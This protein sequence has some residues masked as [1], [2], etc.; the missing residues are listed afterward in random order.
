MSYDHLSADQLRILHDLEDKVRQGFREAEAAAVRK[1]RLHAD[2]LVQD[3][4]TRDHRTSR[5]F[6]AA[7]YV[8]QAED[9]APP[10]NRAGASKDFAAIARY[11]S[12][13]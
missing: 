6:L 4:D 10:P 7:F 8:R 9:E 5:N 2:E 1:L 11:R 3:H 13:L 12:L